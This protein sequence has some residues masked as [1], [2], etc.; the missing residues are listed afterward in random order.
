MTG[1]QA[2][3]IIRELIAVGRESGLV[4]LQDQRDVDTVWSRKPGQ[5]GKLQ[6]MTLEEAEE[7]MDAAIR[8]AWHVMTGRPLPEGE[9]PVEFIEE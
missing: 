1:V 3:E 8:E 7:W 6:V 4:Q 9:D 2:K 5:P